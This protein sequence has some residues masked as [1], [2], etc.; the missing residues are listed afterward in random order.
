[1][2]LRT[3][4]ILDECCRPVDGENVGGR[5]PT[6]TEYA[7]KYGPWREEPPHHGDCEVPPVGYLPWTSGNGVPGGTLVSWFY[8]REHE[9]QHEGRP[10]R[11]SR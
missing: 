5:V 1:V 9:H 3:D 2:I 11:R 10:E 6:I 4:F 7:E 8:I